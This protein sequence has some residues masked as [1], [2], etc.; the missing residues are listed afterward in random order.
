MRI[1][2]SISTLKELLSES[3][4]KYK[5]NT[6]FYLKDK[7]GAIYEVTYEKF[8][9]DCDCFGTALV[10]ELGAGIKAINKGQPCQLFKPEIF[11]IRAAV[12][13]IVADPCDFTA[14][15]YENSFQPRAEGKSLILNSGN[16]AWN[17]HVRYIPFV[18]R[19][20]AE[21]TV[22]THV[23]HAV[24]KFNIKHSAI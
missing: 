6:A 3:E 2:D 4:R 19:G 17:V 23:S 1:M 5:G 8:K 13:G 16:S 24:R 7:G 9:S 14:V 20:S 11:K 12:E 15:C 18:S 22:V 21:N 10:Y